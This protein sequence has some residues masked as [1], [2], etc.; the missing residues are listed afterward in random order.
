L[1][2]SFPGI[3]EYSEP[4]T[5]T[6]FGRGAAI[7]EEEMTQITLRGRRVGQRLA[8]MHSSHCT[9]QVNGPLAIDGSD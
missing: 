2:S 6:P 7:A 1:D 5:N 3:G 9:H 4:M 8:V